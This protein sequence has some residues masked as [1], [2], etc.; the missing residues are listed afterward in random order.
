MG[1]REIIDVT[2]PGDAKRGHGEDQPSAR[3]IIHGTKSHY[4]TSIMRH[5]LCPGGV[6]AP[7]GDQTSRRAFN[8]FGEL[9]LAQFITI[10][11]KSTKESGLRRNVDTMFLFDMRSMRS[12]GIKIFQSP[13]DALMTSQVTDMSH[14][15]AIVNVDSKVTV[16]VGRQVYSLD[17]SWLAY[18]YLMG[19][20][21]TKRT[22]K[23]VLL[24][25]P[26]LAA[27][28]SHNKY[29]DMKRLL[30]DSLHEE[31][32]A[33]FG[34]E[35]VETLLRELISEAAK[36]PIGEVQ[37]SAELSMGT[38]NEV[39]VTLRTSA[40]VIHNEEQP[41]PMEV[42]SD[43]EV[44]EGLGNIA[45]PPVARPSSAVPK[46]V[47]G[48]QGN[49]LKVADLSAPRTPPLPPSGSAQAPGAGSG[50]ASA[51]AGEGQPSAKR[52]RVLEMTYAG[53]RTHTFDPESPNPEIP[54]PMCFDLTSI[55]SFV[56]NQC[57]YQL[58]KPPSEASAKERK[59]KL[60]LFQ[61]SRVTTR[62]GRSDAGKLKQA[63]KSHRKFD[64]KTNPKTGEKFTSIRDRF[65]NDVIYRYRMLS[66]GW[67]I[68]ML[69][70][71][72]KLLTEDILAHPSKRTKAQ[73]EQATSWY[74]THPELGDEQTPAGN[75]DWKS[76]KV[77]RGQLRKGLAD[78]QAGLPVAP[79]I[80]GVLQQQFGMDVQV[81]EDEAGS[82]E[83]QPSA[84]AGK[85][86]GQGTQSS[87]WS[88]TP[89]PTTWDSDWHSGAASSAG[90]AA[91]AWSS[92]EWRSASAAAPTTKQYHPKPPTT[93]T[94]WWD[95]KKW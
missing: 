32:Q 27:A 7:V 1:Y 80:A 66:Q 84:G 14:L 25:A 64:Q 13:S 47:A 52:T 72:Q 42:T 23:P 19:D 94:N 90:A 74:T 26:E 91:P 53:G 5:G 62:S 16:G 88:S 93:N 10:T 20:R 95:N 31:L 4:K 45:E 86:S 56:C 22:L 12:A 21:Q 43:A 30:T 81:E 77:Y 54:C 33:A 59:E 71:L 39:M 35:A 69:D 28:L 50:S 3:T 11:S 57:G 58:F 68:E 87:W 79:Q 24:A 49:V 55:L 46:V 83:A 29:V 70:P 48:S 37:A 78:A 36:P 85:G 6:R 61:Q 15:Q 34:Q 44:S 18:L 92:D 82:G 8:Y 67:S 60:G 38:Y 76:T 41:E 17:F 73:I 89:S 75:P 2:R 9:S 63:M 40:D 65:E 51:S